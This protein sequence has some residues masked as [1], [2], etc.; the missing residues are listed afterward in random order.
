MN[1]LNI[2]KKVAVIGYSGHGFVAVD[3]LLSAGYEVGGYCDQ[4][5]KQYNPFS[6]EYLGKET[7][8]KANDWFQHNDYFI[9]IGDNRI[10][11]RIYLQLIA[12]LP[13]PINAIHPSA[14]ISPSVKSAQGIFVAAGV[15]INP[16]SQIGSGVICNTSCCVDHEC[17]IGD[18]VHIAPGS[19]L[20]GNV[21]VGARTFVGAGS[22]VK[23]GVTI[24]KDVMIGAGAV[25]VKDIADNSVVV[26]NPLRELK[27]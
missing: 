4:E 23:Q 12:K 27:K 1:N 20:C 8:E 15:V 26:G 11:E 5:E 21:E 13:H 10:R 3:I 14:V 9:S 22:V 16:L 18:F 6:L 25:V 17:I 19:I 2:N 7:G 24:G